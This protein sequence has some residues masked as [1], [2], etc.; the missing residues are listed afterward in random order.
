MTLEDSLSD[1]DWGNAP[2]WAAFGT[3]IIAARYAAGAY[4]REER[5]DRVNAELRLRE[6]ATK[7]SAWADLLPE[8]RESSGRVVKSER[9]A[10][11]LRNSSD[12]IIE[13]VVC[14]FLPK[15][16]DDVLHTV[17]YTLVAPGG[18]EEVAL[19]Y[20]LLVQQPDVRAS[21]VDGKGITWIRFRGRLDA[22][23]ADGVRQPVWWRAYEY[24]PG[25]L[26][27]VF[28]QTIASVVSV[29]GQAIAS[30]VPVLVQGGNAV[31]QALRVVVGSV[32]RRK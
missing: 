8:E 6:Q 21:F 20:E 4:R 9:Y 23:T 22:S 31:G 3:A 24:E 28:G 5:R 1:V 7:F 10:L 27:Q 14:D 25:V 12:E 18:R 15:G 11:T 13:N 32:R 29:L 2:S 19:P 16:K 26:V 17:T 30:P